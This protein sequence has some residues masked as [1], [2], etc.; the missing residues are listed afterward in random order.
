MGSHDFI[1]F[2]PRLGAFAPKI[3]LLMGEIQSQIKQLAGVPIPPAA[4]AELRKIYLS[5][6]VHATTAIEGNTLTEQEVRAI[7]DKRLTLPPSREYLQREVENIAHAIDVVGCDVLL[8]HHEKFS[9]DLL[10]HWHSLILADLGRSIDPSVLVGE[11]RQHNVVVG[12]YIGAPPGDCERMVRDFCDWL[13][14]ESVAPAGHE[15]YSL[16]WQVIKAIIAHMML[17]FIH[18]YGDG[19]GRLSRLVEFA[20]LLRAGVP[21]IAAHLLSNFYNA[22]RARY[23]QELQMA[24]GE[25]VDGAYPSDINMLDFVEYALEGYRDLLA[26]QFTEIHKHVLGVLWHDHIH[27]AFPKQMTPTEQRRKQL[28]LGLG[29]IDSDAPF[30]AATIRELTP[31]LAAAYASLS[32]RTINRDLNALTG[33]DLLKREGDGYLPNKDILLGFPRKDARQR[34]IEEGVVREGVVGA[35]R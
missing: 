21:D 9:L 33:M 25:F 2:P 17:A 30:A 19:N 6:G 5:K 4:S 20:M 13:N 1:K 15:R 26:E 27:S 12:R 10:N 31:A 23:R 14:D 24:H 7:L 35:T 11:L 34:R 22:T 16:A 3:W 8:G 29:D 18:P 32:D 28:A